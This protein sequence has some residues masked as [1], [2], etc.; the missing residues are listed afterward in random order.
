MT[1]EGRGITRAQHTEL[2]HHIF[3]LIGLPYEQHT[4]HEF[5]TPLSRW[6]HDDEDTWLYGAY[7]LYGNPSDWLDGAGDSYRA[8]ITLTCDGRTAQNI[9]QWTYHGSLDVRLGDAGVRLIVDD[10]SAVGYLTEEPPSDHPVIGPRIPADLLFER[11]RLASFGD[12]LRAAI[13]RDL[14]R[15]LTECGALWEVTITLLV[16]K[17]IHEMRADSASPDGDPA[18]RLGRECPSF[19]AYDPEALDEPEIEPCGLCESL[20]K[21]REWKPQWWLCTNT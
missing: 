1:T 16:Y 10:V 15:L 12:E 13:E 7:T 8:Q 4:A 2:L 17:S 5:A 14:D 11:R 20:H 9:A 19:A 18:H 3:G 6:P 21:Q